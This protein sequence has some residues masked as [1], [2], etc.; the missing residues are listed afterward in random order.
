MSD[1]NWGNLRRIPRGK[2]KNHP[3]GWGMYYPVD[4][5]DAH[6]NLKSI[7][8]S[9]I[10]NIW[11]QT[12]LAYESGMDKIW[13]VNVGDRKPMEYPISLFLNMA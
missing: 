1:D 5:V 4:Y 13:I 6:R 9:L 3:G 7:N 11:E 8:V 2:E 12:Q 10:Q